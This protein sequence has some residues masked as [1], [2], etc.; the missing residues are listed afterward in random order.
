VSGLDILRWSSPP[1]F[2]STCQKLSGDVG[3]GPA[4]D[5]DLH[6]RRS[7]RWQEKDVRMRTVG[8]HPDCCQAMQKPA[9]S[10]S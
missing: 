5:R 6:P 3:P 9:Q 7:E 2:P 4:T 10:M 8:P 1:G